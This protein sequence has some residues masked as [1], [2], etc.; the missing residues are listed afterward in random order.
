MPAGPRLQ[1]VLETD[2]AGLRRELVGRDVPADEAAEALWRDLAE[3]SGWL[4]VLDNA[5]QPEAVRA[6][7]PPNTTGHIL[8]ERQTPEQGDYEATVATTW[9]MSFQ[10]VEAASPAAAEARRGERAAR[11]GAGGET[12]GAGR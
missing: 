3:R 4:M 2:D 12:A 8:L 1:G 11:E 9:E 5:D 10:V 7:L 6:L